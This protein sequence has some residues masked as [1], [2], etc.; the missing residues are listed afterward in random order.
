[1]ASSSLYVRSGLAPNIARIVATGLLHQTM[2]ERIADAVYHDIA[3]WLMMLLALLI[4]WIECKLLPHLF[5]DTAPQKQDQPPQIPS[6]ERSTR[7]GLEPTNRMRITASVA[8]F[9][10]VAATGVVTGIWTNR[11]ANTS[12]LDAAAARL[13]RLPL[14]IGDWKGQ[15]VGRPRTVKAADVEGFVLASYS[16]RRLARRVGLLLVCGR[17]GPVAVHTPM[18]CGCGLRAGPGSA[19][20]ELVS[21][22]G[23]GYPPAEFRWALFRQQRSLT[24]ELPIWSR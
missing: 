10:I 15:P 18:Y 2:G 9:L 5:I 17:P 20:R 3:G 19:A 21:E 23:P 7:Q 22:P 6:V 8:G 24:S 12:E 14:E 11:W 1:M 13:G 16:N 4:L